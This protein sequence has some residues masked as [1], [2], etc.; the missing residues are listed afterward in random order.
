[1]RSD[2]LVVSL[3]SDLEN[4]IFIY[5]HTKHTTDMV[6][7]K[8]KRTNNDLSQRQAQEGVFRATFCAFCE[9]TRACTRAKLSQKPLAML[10][11]VDCSLKSTVLFCRLTPSA[12]YLCLLSDLASFVHFRSHGRSRAQALWFGFAPKIFSDWHPHTPTQQMPNIVSYHLFRV[13]E[14]SSK[15]IHIKRILI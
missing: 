11:S 10:T 7:E 9:L 6:E 3:I 1:M 14:Y 2:R 8:D 15:N 5:R 13:D 12:D 4:Y